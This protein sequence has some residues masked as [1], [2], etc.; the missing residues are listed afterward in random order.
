[1]E[2][3]AIPRNDYPRP[4][5]MRD[6]GSWRCLNGKWEF[7]LDLS[8]SGLDRR[9]FE[10][11]HLNGEITVPFVPES[12]LSGVCYTDFIAAAWYKRNF[13]IEKSN[14]KRILLHFGAVN[15]RAAVY[16][17]SE[18]AGE[19]EGGYTPFTFDITDLCV[20]GENTVTVYA[21]NDVRN[22]LQPTGK[23]SERYAPY[24]C[25]YSRCT[26]IWQSV[27]LEFVPETYMEKVKF[28]PDVANSEIFGEVTFGGDKL[29]KYLR[30]VVFFDGEEVARCEVSVGHGSVAFSLN[31]PNCKLWDIGCG[32]LYDVT[33]STD[34][35]LV[36]SYFG[37]REIAVSGNKIL[38]NGRSVF[39]RL[40]LD[41]GYYEGGIYTPENADAFEKDISL[42]M[43]AGFNGARMHMKV[44]EPAYIAAADRAGFLLWEEYPSWGLDYEKK[45]VFEAIALGWR[46]VIERDFSS[47]SVICRCPFNE[48]WSKSIDGLL[49]A[50][51]HLT[52]SLDSSRPVI[53]TS[54]YIHSE[55]TD[56][57]DVHDY[58]Q[59]PDEFGKHYGP[60]VTGEGRPF[61]NCP[62]HGKYDGK[63]PYIVSEFGGAFWNGGHGDGE[64][65]NGAWGY[66]TAPKDEKDFINRL[67]A[68]CKILIDN[69][70][71]CGFCYTQLTDVMQE[72]NGLFTFGR[73]AKFDVGTVRDIISRKAAIEDL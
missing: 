57:F 33:L 27:W 65:K 67:D 8:R 58:E 32:N 12:E 62:E 39:Q 34:S 40:I 49:S 18:K 61:E 19:H 55:F 72:K 54:G 22:P 51:Y 2:N 3:S 47:P 25:L 9:L 13:D 68:L 37:M 16:V 5:M 50:I 59:S 38:L 6:D 71:I 42:A 20:T 36:I 11:E 30:A 66:G 29:P 60:L 63:K 14:G 15:Y 46:E 52:K 44:F 41:Q 23:Q 64:N 24:N 28:L 48:T 26:G 10:A 43:S 7:E 73:K 70:G 35:D 53:D 45:G 69:S 56:I 31:I 4:Q 21:E 1:M 17:N